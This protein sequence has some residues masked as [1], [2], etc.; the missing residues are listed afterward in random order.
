MLL[1]TINIKMLRTNSVSIKHRARTPTSYLI[2][3][4]NASVAK[5]TCSHIHCVSLCKWVFSGVLTAAQAVPQFWMSWEEGECRKWW[6][7][8]FE[9]CDMQS[10]YKR[11]IFYCCKYFQIIKC[12]ASLLNSS[13]R[14]FTNVCYI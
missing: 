13:T 10:L 12:L 11:L 6:E 3:K 1:Q 9:K 7:P 5:V 14:S 2:W 4:I 8:L